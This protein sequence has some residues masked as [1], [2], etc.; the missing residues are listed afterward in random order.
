M[1]ISDTAG[2][3]YSVV[4]GPARGAGNDV[5]IALAEDARGGLTSVTVKLTAPVPPGGMD[6]YVLEY[7]GMAPNAF[8]ETANQIGTTSAT[9]GMTSG[10]ATTRAD[11]ELVLGFGVSGIVKP[12]TGFSS[13]SLASGNVVEDKIADRAGPYQATATMVSPETSWTMVMATFRSR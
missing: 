6:L 2:N 13:R 5:Y 7:A 8:D 9:D 10:P 1:E 11:G 3:P 12:G 4:A